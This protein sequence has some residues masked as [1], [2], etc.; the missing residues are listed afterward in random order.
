[1]VDGSVSQVDREKIGSQL[2]LASEDLTLLTDIAV[3]HAQDGIDAN[4]AA[5]WEGELRTHVAEDEGRLRRAA[6]QALGKYTVKSPCPPAHQSLTKAGLPAPDAPLDRQGKIEA[7]R[8]LNL[9]RRDFRVPPAAKSTL[10]LSKQTR[11]DQV[12]KSG[13]P[14]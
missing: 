7:Q 3:N 6:S 2:G 11:T 5:Q 9:I 8:R 4:P 13:K 12:R 1:L 14:S 10:K